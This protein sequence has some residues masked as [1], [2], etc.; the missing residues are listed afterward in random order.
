MEDSSKCRL[1]TDLLR[2]RLNLL[3]GKDKLLMTMYLENGNSYSQMASLAG[4]DVANIARRICKLTKKLLDN[5]Y[6]TCL[7]NRRKFTKTER[8]VAKDYFLNDLSI[9]KITR[10]R[11]LSFYRVRETIKKIQQILLTIEGKN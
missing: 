8:N 1:S 9:R 5:E 3:S 11:N 10:K 2:S 6:I 7:Q 4:I